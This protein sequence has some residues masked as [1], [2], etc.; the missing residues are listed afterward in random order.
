MVTGSRGF[1]DK[2]QTLS[3]SVK[4]LCSPALPFTFSSPTLSPAEGPRSFPEL[5]LQGSHL[6]FCSHLS[7]SLE[8][9]LPVTQ[10]LTFAKASLTT[11]SLLPLNV[12]R[13]RD[14]LYHVQN[15]SCCLFI[16]FRKCLPN[17]RASPCMTSIFLSH[18]TNKA[19]TPN[20]Y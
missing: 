7:S 4:P 10:V 19:V 17:C 12:C 11:L 16:S 2:T 13:V 15:M 20:A 5:A 14:D 3:P 9:L 18:R 1:P 6:C 8:F